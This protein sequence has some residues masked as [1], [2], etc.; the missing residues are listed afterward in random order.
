MFGIGWSEFILVALVLLIFVG[1]KHIPGMLRKFGTIINELRMASRDLRNQIEV[2]VGDLESPSKMVRDIGNDLI[3]D[4]PS[5]Y[6]E[7]EKA[8]REIE[9]ETKKIVDSVTHDEQGQPV[10]AAEKIKK[11][12]QEPVSDEEP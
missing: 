11:D 8:E 10:E 9:Q 1:P 3:K 4:I 7:L 5:P 2:E 6:E 12:T